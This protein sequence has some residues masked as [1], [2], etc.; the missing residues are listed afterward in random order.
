MLVGDLGGCL[1]VN[2]SGIL[3]IRHVNSRLGLNVNF[4]D[5]KKKRNLFGGKT[6][7]IPY[8]H[9]HNNLKKNHYI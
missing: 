1:V 3:N 6:I 2:E 8:R 7:F 9:I 4:S 5:Y